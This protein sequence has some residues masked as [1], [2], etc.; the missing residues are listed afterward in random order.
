M[1]CGNLRLALAA[2]SCMLTYMLTRRNVSTSSAPV[3]QR[4]VTQFFA[5][6]ISL[7][8][9][10]W[11]LHILLNGSVRFSPI[12]G[13]AA[14]DTLYWI[15]LRLVVW[16]TLPFVY[17]RRKVGRQVRFLGLE[18]SHLSR[19]VVYGVGA[20]AVWAAACML[21]AVLQ[22]QT[23]A[24]AGISILG[25]TYTC[26]IVAITEELV[27]RGYLLS[28]IMAGGARLWSANLATTAAFLVPHIV[29]W[30]FQGSLVAHASSFSLMGL[31][32]VSLLMGFVRW[33]SRSLVA[34]IL[35]HAA[36]NLLSLFFS[37]A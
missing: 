26:V 28:G 34:S 32:L 24:W 23:L 17:F 19:G 8:T 13:S 18:K 35:L 6:F 11:L 7:W 12:A 30:A 29:G 33:R 25:A 27:F 21:V 15:A 2:K 36:N 3:R 37:A 31:I 14:L 22:K 9:G 1:P 5:W 16:V 10:A 4:D 20:S